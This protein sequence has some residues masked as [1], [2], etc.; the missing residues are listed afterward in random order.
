MQFGVKHGLDPE[1]LCDAAGVELADLTNREGM[2]PHA[3]Y[4]A[5][6]GAVIER[7]PHLNVAIECGT[8]TSL[9]Q[10]GFLGQAYKHSRTVLDGVRLF[11]FGAG[12]IDSIYQEVPFEISV[13]ESEFVIS[14]PPV[15]TEPPEPP[16]AIEVLFVNGL[17]VM[18][19]LLNSTDS[20]RSVHFAHPRS[21]RVQQQF[22]DYFGCPVFFESERNA[23]VADRALGDRPLPGAS[24][25][26]GNPFATQVRKLF[27]GMEAPI[28]TSAGRA[29]ELLMSKQTLSQVQLAKSLRL[30]VR[31]LQRRLEESGV[32]YQS[33]LM[34]ARLGLAQR[35][36][37][38][39]RVAIQEIAQRLGYESVTAFSRAFR[40]WTGLSPSD[41]RRVRAS[42]P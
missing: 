2:I 31:S 14:R 22:R 30:S 6:Q 36:L 19:E 12:L 38:K 13:T 33:L 29:I 32:S 39:P 8:F 17:H 34:K 21:P 28:V 5:I 18:R 10:L 25:A 37:A 16:E 42:A 23:M 3:W 27:D 11:V 9:D 4:Y 15:E 20:P 35:M 1:E 7:L 41:Y 26:A 24:N 40:K